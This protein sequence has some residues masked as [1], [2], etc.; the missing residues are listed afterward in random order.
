MPLY[1][2]KDFDP[3]YRK[4]FDQDFLGFDLYSGNDKIGSV[5]NLLVD[6]TGNFRY[7]VINTG[8][9]VF[10][11]KVLLP[12]GRARISYQDHRIYADNLNRSQI[13]NL[14]EYDESATVDASH[15]EKVRGVYRPGNAAP[16]NVPVD[17]AAGNA[18]RGRAA[19]AAPGGAASSQSDYAYDRDPD[20]YGM[21]DRDHQNLR[22]YEERLIANKARQ[23]TGE[24]SVG[25]HVETETAR[26]S[27]PVE[28]ER[29]VVERTPGADIGT[30]VDASA[31]DFRE[32]E[33]ARMEV[34]EEVPDIHK[35]TIVRE[36]VEIRK[37]ID[38]DTVEAE[39]QL[40]R[41][42]LNL[43]TQGRPV[44]DRRPDQGA[45][46]KRI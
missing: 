31:T 16:G 29:V 11:K 24:V 41:E 12:I 8:V 22:L 15:E 9:W 26:V 1:K 27:V 38:R 23:K 37:E 43:D 25:K 5:D 13:E 14:P 2:I 32:G 34:Y 28:K 20:L 46:N 10:G 4:H 45:A 44:V 30:P 7:F 39:D 6:E 19:T 35:E 36:N 3:D 18:P 33:V 42:E 21:N 17:T 40:R